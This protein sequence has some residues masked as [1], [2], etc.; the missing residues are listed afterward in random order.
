MTERPEID[1]VVVN[2]GG[3]RVGEYTIKELESIMP[4]TVICRFCHNEV[5]IPKLPHKPT[6]QR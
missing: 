1:K 5:K 3:K 4:D 2:Y 6:E